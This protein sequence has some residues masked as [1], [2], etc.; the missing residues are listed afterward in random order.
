MGMDEFYDRVFIAAIA[1]GASPAGAADIA[2]AS[3]KLR[4]EKIAKEYVPATEFR[5]YIPTGKRTV[6]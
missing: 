2:A 6:L 1:G 4:A 3:V 5:G